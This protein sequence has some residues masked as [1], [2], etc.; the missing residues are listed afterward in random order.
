MKI[1]RLSR[2]LTHIAWTEFEIRSQLPGQ[3][4]KLGSR[5]FFLRLCVLLKIKYNS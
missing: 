5:F 4:L 1:V 3:S 2:K